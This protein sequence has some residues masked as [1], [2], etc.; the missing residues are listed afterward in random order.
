MQETGIYGIDDD[1]TSDQHEEQCYSKA[2]YQANSQPGNSSVT[3]EI[4][5]NADPPSNQIVSNINDKFNF[6]HIYSTINPGDS[7]NEVGQ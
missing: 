3:N 6:V 5:S 4:L 2:G 7:T 1:S